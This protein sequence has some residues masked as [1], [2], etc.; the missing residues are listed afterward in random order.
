MHVIVLYAVTEMHPCHE[1]LLLQEL[2]YCPLY[3]AVHTAFSHISS[4]VLMPSVVLHV[5]L[6]RILSQIDTCEYLLQNRI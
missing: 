6:P 4:D 5:I 1:T 2:T 3:L